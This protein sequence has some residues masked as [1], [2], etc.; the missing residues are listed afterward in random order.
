MIRIE[1][2]KMKTSH[3]KAELKKGR[4]HSWRFRRGN[5]RNGD[6]QALY[7]CS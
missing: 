2:I 4:A 6:Y 1:Q 3:T 7:R 5:H